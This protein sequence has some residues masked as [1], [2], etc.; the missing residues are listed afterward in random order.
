MHSGSLESIQEARVALGYR[1]VQLFRIFLF[2]NAAARL[3]CYAPRHCHITP[4]LLDLHWLP[5]KEHTQYK[6]LLFV[7]KALHGFA[8]DHI[9]NLAE[10]QSG[11]KYNLQPT[12][13]RLLVPFKDKTKKTIGDWSFAVATPSLWN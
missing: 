5:V 10:L 2:F 13:S 12:N 9:T 7:F 11:S 3:V 8:P 4:L 6:V 1:L